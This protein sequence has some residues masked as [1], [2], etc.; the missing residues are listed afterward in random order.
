M[1]SLTVKRHNTFQKYNNRKA[2]DSFAPRTM[3]FKSQQELLNF[4]DTCMSSPKTEL[5]TNFLNLENRNFEN[6]RFS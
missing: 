1:Y 5:E 4:N 6:V 2:T 3:I